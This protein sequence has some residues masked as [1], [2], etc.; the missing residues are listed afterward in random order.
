MDLQLWKFAMTVHLKVHD[1][2]IWQKT[3][4]FN[5]F[6]DISDLLNGE[7]SFLSYKHFT[8]SSYAMDLCYT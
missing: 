1:Q 2:H 3:S 8:Q 7:L 4:K 5:R 6:A